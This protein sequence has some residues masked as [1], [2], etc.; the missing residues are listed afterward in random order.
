MAV[1][2]PGDEP[3]CPPHPD[4]VGRRVALGL[5]RE[6]DRNGVRMGAQQVLPDGIAATV[7]PWAGDVDLVHVGLAH[8]PQVRGELLKVIRAVLEV[9]IYQIKQGLSAGA[10]CC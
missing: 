3:T 4:A 10:G 9:L 7:A 6:L 8:S 1:P 2:E 5:Q